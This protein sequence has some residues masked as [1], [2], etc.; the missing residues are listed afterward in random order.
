MRARELRRSPR[1]RPFPPRTSWRW[2][3]AAPGS[4]CCGGG[5]LP[6]VL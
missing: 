5:R 2:S 1:R 4:V 3:R 6:R